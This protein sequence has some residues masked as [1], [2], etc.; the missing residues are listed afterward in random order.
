[1]LI[2]RLCAAVKRAA[3]GIHLVD[4]CLMLFMILLLIQSAC[5]VFL[6][7]G[8]GEESGGVDI[9]VRTSSAAIFGYFL[10]ANFNR[11]AS[12]GAAGQTGLQ[13]KSIQP[14]ETGEGPTAQI[15][16]RAADTGT[17]EVLQR[18]EPPADT[19]GAEQM[20]EDRLQ[21]ITAAGIGLFSLV[22]LLLLRW[23]GPGEDGAA[24]AA[25]A[26]LRDFVSGSVGFLIGC[27]TRKPYETQP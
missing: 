22:M 9:I 23:L 2:K 7:G 19:T 3:E 20:P 25:A 16:F 1:M 11:R 8:G 13:G 27:P 24:V 12:S 4:R 10:S 17:G 21:I 14:A 26:Q 5:S 15:G 18:P 6:P